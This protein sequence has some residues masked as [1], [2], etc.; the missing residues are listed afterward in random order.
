MSTQV[1]F[2]SFILGVLTKQHDLSSDTF[3]IFLTNSAPN[4]ATHSVKAD[5]TEIAAGNGYPAGGLTLTVT[6][7]TQT[8]G[9]ASVAV[10]DPPVLT[11]TGGPIAEFRYAVLYNETTATNQLVSYFDYGG[12]VNLKVNEKL[13]LDAAAT[14]FTGGF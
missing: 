13:T 3:K 6:G 11:A 9:V 2:D 5:L 7:V 10:N 8:G 14:L 12:A 4:Q 1:N